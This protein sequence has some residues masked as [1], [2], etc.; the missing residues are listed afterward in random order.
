MDGEMDGD[1]WM[2]ERRNKWRDGWMEEKMGKLEEYM[3][4]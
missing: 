2:E 1:E 4:G 3:E